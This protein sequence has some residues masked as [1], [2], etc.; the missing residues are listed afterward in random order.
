M[1]VDQTDVGLAGREAEEYKY[2]AGRCRHYKLIGES[3]GTAGPN[4]PVVSRELCKYFATVHA[5]LLAGLHK[6][7]T[8]YMYDVRSGL[9]FLS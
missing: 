5:N 3:H 7:Q 9:N 6:A 4:H 8:D 1:R 2:L